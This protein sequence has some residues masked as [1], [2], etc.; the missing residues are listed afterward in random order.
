[1]KVSTQ[2]YNDNFSSKTNIRL[3]SKSDYYQQSIPQVSV[4]NPGS[5]YHFEFWKNPNGNLYAC[6]HVTHSMQP[7]LVQSNLI[8][9]IN[10]IS[11]HIINSINRSLKINIKNSPELSGG[12][13]HNTT[14]TFNVA[15]TKNP[16]LNAE[17]MNKLITFIKKYGL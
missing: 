15:C 13:G 10:D 17:I 11:S 16:K 9:N 8:S 4:K 2:I 3:E 12:I 1:M 14:H 6:L 7:N 5:S